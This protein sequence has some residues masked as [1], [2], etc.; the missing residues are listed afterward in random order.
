M[1]TYGNQQLRLQPGSK[2]IMDN[3]GLATG[4]AT[5]KAPRERAYDLAPKKGALHPYLKFLVLD[6]LEITFTE[7]DA[8]IVGEFA[9]MAPEAG[10]QQPVYELQIGVSEENVVLHPDFV[11]KIGGRP[12]R[13]LNGAVFINPGTGNVTTDDRIGVFE[14]FSLIHKG[15]KNP[16]A[17][18]E[19]YL[20]ASEIVWRKK[21]TSRSRPNDIGKVGEI[22]NPEGPN[23]QLGRG[24]NWLYIGMSYSQRG[25][26]YSVS[27]EWRAS[28]RG[29]WNKDLYDG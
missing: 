28:A 5:W 15:E 17:G 18:I 25:N 29:G 7:S 19:A 20:D 6:R 27:K 14:K 13:P 24:R 9:G 1:K 23:P 21:Y 26:V 2:V 3:T 12:S 16:F 10:D 4:T 11:T 22:D 8:V